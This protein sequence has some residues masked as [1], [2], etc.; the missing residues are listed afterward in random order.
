[1]RNYP[2]RLAILRAFNSQS[3]FA[4]E[5]S[6]H[7]STVSRVLRGRKKLSQEKAS[8]WLETLGCDRKIIEEITRA[9]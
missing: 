7:E 3:D 9:D 5:I 6:E 2:L 1:M 4:F 8:I